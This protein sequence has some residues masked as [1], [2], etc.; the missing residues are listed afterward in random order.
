M[1]RYG[2]AA[3]VAAALFVWA[4]LLF[5]PYDADRTKAFLVPAGA[6]FGAILQRSRFCFA[7]GFRDL[8]LLR[9]RRVMLGLLAALAVGSAGYLV[10]FGLRVPDAFHTEGFPRAA[11]I[12]PAGWHVIAGG[13]SFGL[14]MVLAGGCISGSLYRLGEGNLTAPVTLAAAGLGYW[15]GFLAWP[16]L[17][18]NTVATAPVVWLPKHL[19]WAGS[20]ALYLAAFAG[21]AA[22]LLWKFPAMP[23]KPAEPVTLPVALR[24]GFRDGW[25]AVV[26]GAAIGVLATFTYQHNQP[27]GVT[28]ELGRQSRQRAN[29]L[30]LTFN[31]PGL[32]QMRG[33]SA[34]VGESGL[35]PNAIFVL[36]LVGGSLVMALLAGEFRW[37]VGRPRT[38]LL[39]AVGGVLLGFGAMISLG[40]TVG[41]LLSGVMAF[42][43]SGWLFA[44]GLAGGAWAG[45]RV[46]K[47]LA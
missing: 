19:G 33:C 38:Y 5:K 41:T 37:R 39:G 12:S 31:L 40:C 45:G 27:L 26:G 18:V 11:H 14:G 4:L 6:A 46:L 1:V 7:S 28:S 47:A 43:L 20:M 9:D 24:R 15:L 16:F 35:T 13:L 22:L 34:I 10:V 8:F 30:G 17:W 44:L 42:S 21:L 25:P 36:S 2:A 23:P 32:D 29:E 3:V